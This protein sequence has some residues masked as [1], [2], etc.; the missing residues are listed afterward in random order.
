MGVGTN[1]VC[2]FELE[3]NSP[4]SYPA[5]ARG[6]GEHTLGNQ[7]QQGHGLGYY[8][9]QLSLGLHRPRR[10]S[11]SNSI[12]RDPS[13]RRKGANRTP[14]IKYASSRRRAAQCTRIVPAPNP[15][16][17]QPFHDCPTSSSAKKG[18]VDASYVPTHSARSSPQES[19]TTP[20]EMTLSALAWLV[21]FAMT[22]GLFPA[23]LEI[24]SVG[25]GKF[26]LGKAKVHGRQAEGKRIFSCSKRSTWCRTKI[27][28]GPKHLRATTSMPPSLRLPGVA[29]ARKYL[30]CDAAVH[31]HLLRAE[32]RS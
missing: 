29:P 16:K 11:K 12:I 18:N 25:S 20:P 10:N 26:P 7:A 13:S 24:P 30:L 28:W 5:L 31:L 8:R 23:V 15:R 2:G 32:R 3:Y 9:V 21:A 6:E 27:P 22:Y 4:I 19:M 1:A 17:T 14:K